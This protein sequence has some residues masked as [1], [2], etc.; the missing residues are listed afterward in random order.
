MGESLAGQLLLASPTLLDPNFSR[1]VVLIGVHSSEGALGVILN[2]PSTVTVEE[3]V[4]ALQGAVAGE[5]P[6][7]VGGPV[8]PAS[9]VL[10]ERKR[11]D[12]WNREQSLPKEG[13]EAKLLASMHF[14]ELEI[15]RSKEGTGLRAH[16]GG[17]AAGV[18]WGRRSQPDH[19]LGAQLPL[20]QARRQRGPGRDHGG[21]GL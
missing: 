7:Y 16:P 13:S 6:V 20:D 8:Q 15:S 19:L 4:P 9:V 3:A 5:E 18:R 14:L 12:Q 17:P 10:L 1:T 2:R 11:L 21:G